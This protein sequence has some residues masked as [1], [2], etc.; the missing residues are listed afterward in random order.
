M[1]SLLQWVSG[2]FALLIVGAF[3]WESLRF[4]RTDLLYRENTPEA[5]RKAVEMEPGNAAYHMLR[6]EH[7]EGAGEDPLPELIQSSKLSPFDSQIL[8]RVAMRA[9]SVGDLSRS[10]AFLLRAAA[11]DKKFVPRWALANYYFRRGN[12][13]EFWKWLGRSLEMSSPED[14]DGIFR[15][16][17]EQS[18]DGEAI[19]RHI[20][21]SRV[22]AARYLRFL[23]RTE[24]LEAA[25]VVA[26]RA[27]AT[28]TEDELPLLLTFCERA[29]ATRS[30][31][32]VSVWN[33]MTARKLLP[34]APLDPSQGAIV[35]NKDFLL[36]P[37]PRGFD[38]RIPSVEGVYAAQASDGHGLTATLSGNQPED[39][40]LVEQILPLIPGK[41][42]RIGYE[43]SALSDQQVAGL[44]WELSGPA[45]AA[46]TSPEMVA[47]SGWKTG[48]ILFTATDQW[49]KLSL[50]YHRASGK[51]RAEGTIKIRA[52]T[53][54]LMK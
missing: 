15:M 21:D 31:D 26:R 13:E 34:F 38:W 11:V 32:A 4:A 33:V 30:G 39:C 2:V 35:G 45:G 17:W 23:I 25:A 20:P 40:V 22:I 3:S 28:A 1:K 50:R 48:Q 53:D 46:A 43:Y 14:S 12:G 5:L 29:Q 37:S 8:M 41:R 27:A 7:R 49:G 47:G 19:L 24:R 54:Q 51:V 9:E 52:L 18:S 6:A 16:A 10:E 44:Q 36:L 42:Y